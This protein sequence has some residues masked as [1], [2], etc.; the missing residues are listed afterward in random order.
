M[1][2]SVIISIIAV[3]IVAGVIVLFVTGMFNKKEEKTEN[4]TPNT[5]TETSTKSNLG[6]IETSEDLSKLVDKLYE[7]EENVLPSLQTQEVDI[8]DDEMVK[9]ITGLD[10]G[11]DLEFVV[12]SEP[13]MSSQAYSLILAKVKD[14]VNANDVAKLM[15]EKVDARKW[16]CVTAEKVYATSSNDVVIVIMSS[17]DMAK[18]I[19][20]KFKTLA[21]TVAQEYERAGE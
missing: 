11:K 2:K 15:H 21:G 13:M 20:E 5:S 3:L 14:G 17:E 16:I 6:T 12:V 10:N 8:S 19:Y 4:T 7:N 9:F 1:K 18:P